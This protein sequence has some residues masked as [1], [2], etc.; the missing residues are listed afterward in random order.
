MIHS[1]SYSVAEV[2]GYI[3]WLYFFHAWHFPSNFGRIVL[4]N[5]QIDTLTNWLSYIPDVEPQKA[6]EAF[7]L[8]R[9]AQKTLKKW[10]E[11]SLQ[12]HFKV[13]LYAAYSMGD[14]VWLPELEVAI[15]FLRQQ[16]NKTKEPCLCWSDFV[17]P[18]T[19]AITSDTIG[20]FAATVDAEMEKWGSGDEY[21]RL[22]SQ[23]LADRLAEATAEVGH[24]KV[25]KEIWG[26]APHEEYTLAQLFAS[27]YQGCRPAVGYPSLPDQSL[28]FILDSLLDFKDIGISLTENGAMIPHASTAGLMFAHPAAHYFDVGT[29]GEDQFHD[30]AK[31]RG[32]HPDNLRRFLCRFPV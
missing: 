31:R 17:R 13:A 28:I 3:N 16:H 18:Q 26:Y 5:P 14:N 30:Y 6:T 23:T 12:T 32:L 7:R 15:P 9:D 1:Q 22:L 19:D 20:I 25:R 10:S 8:W 21:Q 11:A 27:N 29:I 2:V 4:E 24:Q